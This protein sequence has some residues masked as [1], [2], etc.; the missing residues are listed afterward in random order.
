MLYASVENH[1]VPHHNAQSIHV[2]EKQ[3]KF[4]EQG[5]SDL[6]S[7]PQAIQGTRAYFHRA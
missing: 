6:N 4:K 3:V 7:I 5:I 1:T 2:D